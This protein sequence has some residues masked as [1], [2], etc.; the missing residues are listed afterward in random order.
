MNSTRHRCPV[1]NSI[2]QA[3]LGWRTNVLDTSSAEMSSWHKHV[4]EFVVVVEFWTGHVWCSFE[5]WYKSTVWNHQKVA[6]IPEDPCH[7]TK[8]PRDRVW[9]FEQRLRG[10]KLIVTNFIKL[11]TRKVNELEAFRGLK[12][13]SK[14]VQFFAILGMC[15]ES[16]AIYDKLAL[17]CNLL[18]HIRWDLGG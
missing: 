7:P 11:W 18:N 17:D 9:L 16:I 14:T 2:H 12:K 4:G 10:C 6:F 5:T 15:L 3:N 13:V 8:V 1:T